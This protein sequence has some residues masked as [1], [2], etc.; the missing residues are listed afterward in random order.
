MNI[1]LLLII[2]FYGVLDIITTHIALVM[3]YS[4]LNPVGIGLLS[5]GIVGL[6]VG[7]T[8]ALS[9]IYIVYKIC[10]KYNVIWYWNIISIMI[11][12]LGIVITI[13]NSMVILGCGLL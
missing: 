3:G 13:N 4:E 10:V 1:R 8:V 9:A 11:I 2:I 5:Y 12:V 6:I 7:K